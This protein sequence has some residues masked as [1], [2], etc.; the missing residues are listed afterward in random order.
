LTLNFDPKKIFALINEYRN[1]TNNQ[2]PLSFNQ[3]FKK[4][5]R[6]EVLPSTW[7]DFHSLQKWFNRHRNHEFK[8]HWLG[9][10][11]KPILND[12]YVDEKTR[13]LLYFQDKTK[14]EQTEFLR[15][16]GKYFVYRGIHEHN[17]STKIVEAFKELG[18]LNELN[19]ENIMPIEFKN[20]E[21]VEKIKYQEQKLDSVN[22]EIKED[23]LLSILNELG[24]NSELEFR[25]HWFELKGK[26][27]K[28]NFVNSIAE[29]FMYK[30]TPAHDIC[31]KIVKGFNEIGWLNENTVREFCP[32]QFKDREMASRKLGK[33][34]HKMGKDT[35]Q[36]K[37]I[38]KIAKEKFNELEKEKYQL[39]NEIS[40]LE[41]K[42]IEKESQKSGIKSKIKNMFKKKEKKS[43]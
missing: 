24:I 11:I 22:K 40:R 43:K 23:L 42:I 1:P 5:K 10:I 9:S 2:K 14:E 12:F 13:F 21:I 20:Q 32:D 38:K 27:S 39:E 30:G 37:N 17:V 34:F 4:L 35:K 15:W 16:I 25:H 6:L 8:Y 26:D 3:I 41:K 29:K 36:D 18:W 19:L 7:K 31:S 28:V 33:T